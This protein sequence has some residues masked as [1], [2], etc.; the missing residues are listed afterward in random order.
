M[1]A[2]F[3]LI[4]LSFCLIS[5][6]YINNSEPIELA[7]NLKKDSTT[8]ITLLF[9]GD[10]MQHKPQLNAAKTSLGYDYSLCFQHIQK[11]VRQ[12]DLAIANLET[13]LGGKPY[14]GYPMFSSPNELLLELI[15]TGFNVIQIA[16]NHILDRG[17]KGLKRTLFLL[18]S[19]NVYHTG[20]YTSNND[21]EEKTPL[22]IEKKGF[23]IAFLNYTYGT[24]GLTVDSPYIVNYIDTVIIK[25][26]LQTAKLKK[27]DA[28]ITLLHWGE[29][30]QKNPNKEQK[31]LA[32]W[33]INNGVDYII[34]SH[35]HVIQPI[36]VVTDSLIK[37]KKVIAY[38]LGNFI[39]N[40]NKE[41]TDGGIMLKL[42]LEK[43][44]SVQLKSCEYNLVWTGKPI[45][46]KEKNFILYPTSK[47]EYKLNTESNQL[48]NKFLTNTSKRLTR[49]NQG[50][51]EYL[52]E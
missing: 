33:L 1:K 5:C 28:I 4:S 7:A 27:P 49:Y 44:S 30:Y 36:H 34:G 12:A 23:K 39:S 18:D 8:Q 21:R 25:K 46:T 15:N 17:A 16:N 26:D 24:N 51:T 40:M 47:K 11:E 19:L 52:L 50:C 3:L 13:T 37:Q 41:G 32:H 42:I 35:P 29:E 20:A 6:K 9:V 14:S 45:I 43:D 10:V 48:R 22:L 38:S 31:K 2:Y